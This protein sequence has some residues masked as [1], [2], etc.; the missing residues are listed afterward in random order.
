VRRCASCDI[1]PWQAPRPRYFR[2]VAWRRAPPTST[3]KNGR[4]GALQL[5]LRAE[6]RQIPST[7]GRQEPIGLR[8]T[9]LQKRLV[10]GHVPLGVGPTLAKRVRQTGTHCGSNSCCSLGTHPRAWPCLKGQRAFVETQAE[11]CL[12][13]SV[14][15]LAAQSVWHDGNRR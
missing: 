4:R 5:A 6:P 8:S 14:S 10:P 12:G 7:M 15:D 13:G 2:A 11:H 1:V 3:V 9:C